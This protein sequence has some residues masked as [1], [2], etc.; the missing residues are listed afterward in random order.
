[1]K[2]NSNL[3][4]LLILI[5]IFLPQRTLSSKE[6]YETR[7]LA[8]NIPD[9]MKF[10]VNNII[11][12]TEI[13]ILVPTIK[14]T[15]HTKLIAG[16]KAKKESY[17][18]Y[19]GTTS[20]CTATNCSFGRIG[21][22]LITVKT[23]DYDREYKNLLL[24]VPEIPRNRSLTFQN[25]SNKGGYVTLSRKIKGFF[26]PSHCYAYCNGATIIWRQDK[27]QYFVA[28]RPSGSLEELIKFA[29]SAIENQP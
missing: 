28:Y 25:I 3:L 15:D 16:S 8:K 26:M 5:C 20:N 11:G 21:G 2:K 4:Q 7:V 27:Y 19:Y 22:E 12:K 23:R 14:P 17:E 9:W 13:P 18:I 10:A 6:I 24:T 29:N 1:M